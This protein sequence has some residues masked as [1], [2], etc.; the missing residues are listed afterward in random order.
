MKEKKIAA[1]RQVER[2]AEERRQ[3]DAG[4]KRGRALE[5]RRKT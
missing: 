3:K 5:R 4:S 1:Q 2:L